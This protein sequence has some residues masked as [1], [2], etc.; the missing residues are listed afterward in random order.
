MTQ[1]QNEILGSNIESSREK[2][3][4]HIYLAVILRDSVDRL[5]PL[6]TAV[7]V[8]QTFHFSATCFR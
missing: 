1:E 3:I 8:K 6:N 5:G 7:P 2:Y 4:A